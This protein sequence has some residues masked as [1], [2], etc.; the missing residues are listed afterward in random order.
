MRTLRS[1]RAGAV[2]C[3]QGV[4][5]IACVRSAS[6]VNHVRPQAALLAHGP[7]ACT[8]RSTIFVAASR[9]NLVGVAGPKPGP[10][11]RSAELP[12]KP[13]H[14]RWAKATSGCQD[15]SGIGLAIFPDE[16]AFQTDTVTTDGERRQPS[17]AEA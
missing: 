2:L 8:S 6:P 1:P 14:P 7:L 12:S 3:C 16:G 10:G 5:K 15:T 11:R 4:S 9:P 17:V 13:G